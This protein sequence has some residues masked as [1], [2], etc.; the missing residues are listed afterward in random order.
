MLE[1]SV[2][3]V[4]QQ[5]NPCGKDKNMDCSKCGSG[6]DISK[7]GWEAVVKHFAH[8]K[9][10]ISA[11]G[12]GGTDQITEGALFPPTQYFVQ[13][14]LTQLK[15]SIKARI[16]S[17]IAENFQG[18]PVIG[19]HHRHG[20]GEIDDFVDRKTGKPIGRLNKNNTRVCLC[21]LAS[22]NTHKSI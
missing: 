10:A 5:D 15:P 4:N 7:D 21:L 16:E 22:L 12:S 13:S 20:N 18:L 8:D 19:V 17:F 11:I 3:I 1:D 6:N 14:L 2:D 9:K